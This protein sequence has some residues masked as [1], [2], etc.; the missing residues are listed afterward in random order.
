M[1]STEV[2]ANKEKLE[3]DIATHLILLIPRLLQSI[4]IANSPK[5]QF[6]QE[7]TGDSRISI[8]EAINHFLE[9]KNRTSYQGEDI[10]CKTISVNE[11]GKMTISCQAYG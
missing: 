5:V 11:K 7:H 10:E 4:D 2:T 8:S 6:I 3:K 1:I 9:I